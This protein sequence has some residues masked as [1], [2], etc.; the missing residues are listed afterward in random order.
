MAVILQVQL[1]KNDPQNQPILSKMSISGPHKKLSSDPKIR[2]Q[3]TNPSVSRKI[4][5]YCRKLLFSWLFRYFSHFSL[6]YS[7]LL[8]FNPCVQDNGIIIRPFEVIILILYLVRVKKTKFRA[9][10]LGEKANM[11]IGLIQLSLPL[12]SRSGALES[13][14]QQNSLSR[15]FRSSSMELVQMDPRWG[16]ELQRQFFYDL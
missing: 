1:F 8:R 14:S 5:F 3:S 9:S 7:F 2:Q 6:W 11:G 12:S 16:N 4:R 10:F 13:I 15:G